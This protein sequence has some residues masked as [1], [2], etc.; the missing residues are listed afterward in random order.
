MQKV[1][2]DSGWLSR[3]GEMFG[4]AVIFYALGANKLLRNEKTTISLTNE[5][6]LY[7]HEYFR[8]ISVGWL[9]YLS[10]LSGGAP[11]W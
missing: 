2:R 4:M 11:S 3:Y 9:G 1:G 5:H 6:S 8:D 7:P 10:Y